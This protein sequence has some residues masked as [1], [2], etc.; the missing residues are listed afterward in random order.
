MGGDTYAPINGPV[1][2]HFVKKVYEKTFHPYKR[3]VGICPF[4]IM[5]NSPFTKQDTGVLCPTSA[6]PMWEIDGH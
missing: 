2:D 1:F 4:K 6:P 3:R 5:S